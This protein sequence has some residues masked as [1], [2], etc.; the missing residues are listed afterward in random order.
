[1]FEKREATFRGLI[2]MAFG[3]LALFITITVLAPVVATPIFLMF[4][5]LSLAHFSQSMIVFLDSLD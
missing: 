4:I 1:M 5:C 3:A 2:G